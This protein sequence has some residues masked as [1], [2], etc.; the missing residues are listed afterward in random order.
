MSLTGFGTVCTRGTSGVNMPFTFT[1][2]IIFRGSDL[3]QNIL[4]LDTLPEVN[5]RM[6]LIGPYPFFVHYYY[7]YYYFSAQGISDTEGE[8]KNS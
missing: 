3:R 7:Y 2:M 4:R 8:E 5:Q 6:L 1:A